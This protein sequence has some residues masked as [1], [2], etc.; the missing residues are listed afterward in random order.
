MTAVTITTSDL[1]AAPPELAKLPL[2]LAYPVRMIEGGSDPRWDGS[3]SAQTIEAAKDA[4]GGLLGGF[5]AARPSTVA[6]WLLP[7]S[8]AVRNAPDERVFI[9]LVTAVAVACDNLP[10]WAFNRASLREALREFSFMPSAA[11]VAKLLSAHAGASVRRMRALERIARATPPPP[12]SCPTPDDRAAVA[13]KIADFRSNLREGPALENVG[14]THRT[15]P[16][17]AE[18]LDAIRAAAGIKRAQS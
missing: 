15:K 4:L 9:G 7:V 2:V 1:P 17:H 16:I 12:A 3:L 6:A 14:R 18:H 13:A 8:A 11:D 5:Q 10:A